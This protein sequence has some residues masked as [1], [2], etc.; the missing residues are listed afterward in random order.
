[1]AGRGEELTLC[2]LRLRRDQILLAI[3]ARKLE[4]TLD[5]LGELAEINRALGEAE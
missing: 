3:E 1:M 2:G 5:V 4:P